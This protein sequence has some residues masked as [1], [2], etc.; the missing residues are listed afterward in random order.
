MLAG[1]S[2][3]ELAG[4]LAISP[5]AIEEAIQ[6][7]LLAFVRHRN[8][9]SWRFGDSRNGSFRRIDGKPF[10]IN[11]ESVKAEAETRGESWHCLI[12]LDDVVANERRDVLLI[13]EGTKDALAALHF[14]DV[15]GTLSCIGVV[16]ALGA[17]INL[18]PDDLEKCRGRRVRIIAD[19]DQAGVK[20]A[21]RI[22]ESLAPVAAEA[23][24]FS[25]AGLTRDDG[26]QVED[27]FDLSRIDY[28]D[29]ESN[30]DLWSITDLD[31]KGDRTKIISD[32]HEFFPSPLFP[33]HGSPESHGFPVYPV[34]NPPELEEAAA[35]NACTERN[36]ARERRWQLARDLTAVEKRIARKLN[37]SELMRTFN[38]WYETSLP[39]LD[40]KKS[41]DDYCGAFLAELGKV[42]VPT[43]GGETLK[44]AL[45]RI[46]ASSLPEIP[47]RPDAPPPWRHLAGLHRE[48][49][50]QSGN[51]TYFLSCRNAA[52]AHPSLNKDSAN[53][54]TW[55]LVRL[56][57]IS[58]VRVGGQRPG[59]KASEFRYLPASKV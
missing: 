20:A 16:V 7:R 36:T 24:V 17:G 1:N 39:H 59:A 51:R 43:G 48:L 29:F 28:N 11:G 58:I 44:T 35:H 32:K 18:L 15:E 4:Q 53:K 6:R 25:L 41:R 55:A 19:V 56:G 12:G 37:P 5:Q 49:S 22:G 31:S 9:R 10:R 13:P 52:Q 21:T 42:R 14:A 50:R 3:A 23:Q 8:C 34:S 30:R 26:S 46:S 2:A 33:P 54:I 57:M 47:G 40:P 38:H 45:A 27:L